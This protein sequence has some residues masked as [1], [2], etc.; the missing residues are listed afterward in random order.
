MPANRAK[1]G[2]NAGAV[3]VIVI[4]V[5]VGIIILAAAGN[6]GLK[7]TYQSVNPFEGVSFG[8]EGIDYITF[9]AFGKAEIGTK[10][11]FGGG[12]RYVDSSYSI[13]GNTIKLKA[14]WGYSNKEENS[15]TYEQ[16]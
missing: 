14:E 5:I 8:Y 9:K 10:S 3:A 13:S 4:L 16:Y 7:G 1:N 11:F 15:Y 6:S 2:T 12:T